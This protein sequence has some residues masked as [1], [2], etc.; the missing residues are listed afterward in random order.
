MYALPLHRRSGP[1]DQ[2]PPP[3][4][5]THLDAAGAKCGLLPRQTPTAELGRQL[6]A[7]STADCVNASMT[8]NVAALLIAIGVYPFK[9]ARNS[10]F[11][12]VMQ[13]TANSILP[14][15]FVSSTP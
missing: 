5:L 6:C 8:R 11:Y 3:R 7:Y 1:L 13:Y 10:F 9:L 2:W 4:Q 12:P 14:S 15:D